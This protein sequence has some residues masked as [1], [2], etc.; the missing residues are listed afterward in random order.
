[1]GPEPGAIPGA[2]IPGETPAGAPV[3]NALLDIP[4]AVTTDVTKRRPV[5]PPEGPS[6]SEPVPR[7]AKMVAVN[8]CTG[9]YPE[10]EPET[11][12]Q[13]ASG[14][15]F[16]LG[17]DNTLMVKNGRM[18]VAAGKG[19]LTVKAQLAQVVLKS[20]AMALVETEDAK[21]TRITVLETPGTE[22][23]V[24]QVG[25]AT[26][27]VM[28]SGEEL[29]V[30]PQKLTAEDLASA[31]EVSKQY[32]TTPMER[33]GLYV[34]RATIPLDEYIEKDP[35]LHCRNQRLENLTPFKRMRQQQLAGKAPAKM[36]Y[37]DPKM[38]LAKQTSD[39][40]S[41][42]MPVSYNQIEY[43]GLSV[44]SPD[45]GAE[46][47][48]FAQTNT[49]ITPL[50]Y[51]P[52]SVLPDFPVT[53]NAH[54]V[55]LGRDHYRL[56]RGSVLAHSRHNTRIDTAHGA[57]IA[58]P[59]STFTISVEDDLTRVMNLA[60]KRSKSVNVL[61]D[62]HVVPLSPGREATLTGGESKIDPRKLVLKDG[63]ARR[64]MLLMQVSYG[65]N[66]VVND[67]SMV[68]ALHK[69]P[70]LR[71]LRNSRTDSNRQMLDEI[72]KTAAARA[73]TVD[74]VRGPYSALGNGAP[75]YW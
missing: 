55:E 7:G 40:K 60:D 17:T 13:A 30:S 28:S 16:E 53:D 65:Q 61:V 31:D 74:K 3:I 42:F 37:L 69:H 35:L 66:I 2:T 64:Y 54:L 58:K 46:D 8:S 63:L 10:D 23:V 48:A 25:S 20:Q 57:I 34:L 32:S 59:G 6:Q 4:A 44:L 18:L 5:F 19:N 36:G 51:L 22:E 73:V 70:L 75:Q 38:P 41:T 72:T 27:V 1:P 9:Y 33:E 62:K 26:F 39:T 45:T 67:F 56:V 71:A 12:M 24:V 14:T 21:P 52:T 68:D 29:V 49:D 15:E 47:I 43:Q 50:T 11:Y